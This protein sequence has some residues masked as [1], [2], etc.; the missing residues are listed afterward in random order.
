MDIYDNENNDLILYKLI[1]DNVSTTPITTLNNDYTYI[2]IYENDYKHLQSVNK[3]LDPIKYKNVV[4]NDLLEY[5]NNK[6]KIKK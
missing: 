4:L 2:N 6:Y 1:K 3:C 5:L